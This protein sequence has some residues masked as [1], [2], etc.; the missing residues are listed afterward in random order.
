MVLSPARATRQTRVRRPT[1]RAAP[2]S[3]GG[4]SRREEGRRRSVEAQRQPWKAGDLGPRDGHG[5][6]EMASHLVARRE[7]GHA[8]DGRRDERRAQLG[9]R[10]VAQH[11][12]QVRVEHTPVKKGVERGRSAVER[13]RSAVERG[14][15]AVER[16]AM[17]G[18]QVRQV[19]HAHVAHVLVQDVRVLVGKGLTPLEKAG[20]GQW[21]TCGEPHARSRMYRRPQQVGDGLSPCRA[22]G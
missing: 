15:S 11:E 3:T 17:R 14:R 19:E 1:C 7:E 16:A 5:R 20:K 8:A 13:G 10:H 6:W 9:A 18:E 22:R 4:A 2:C 12:H 21:G